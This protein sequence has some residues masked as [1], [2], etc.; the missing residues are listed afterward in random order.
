MEKMRLRNTLK[1]NK[2]FGILLCTLAV[3]LLAMSFSVFHVKAE[4]ES[5][6]E[7]AVTSETESEDASE[8]PDPSSTTYFNIYKYLDEDGNFTYT[9][10]DGNEH[11]V[12]YWELMNQ[13]RKL[14]Y[15]G[16]NP[17]TGLFDAGYGKGTGPRDLDEILNYVITV[18]VNED[19]TLHMLYHIDW[20]VL[21][22]TSEGPLTWIC[23]GVPNT[24]CK[25]VKKLSSTIKSIKYTNS[26]EQKSGS[27]VKIVLDRAYHKD[28]VVS[29]DF[30]FTQDYM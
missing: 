15:T 12:N 11:K 9:D 8:S 26:Y 16:V 19:A 29:F 5:E 13:N 27:Y 21:N 18:D 6:T 20:K 4:P 30:E 22:D 10:D 24:H 14:I 1:K 23:I 25:K 28:E 3:V 2:S 7:S 17:D